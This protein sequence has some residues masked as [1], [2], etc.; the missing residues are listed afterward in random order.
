MY[1][2]PSKRDHPTIW[3]SKKIIKHWGEIGNLLMY[4]DFHAHASKKGVFMF[5][6][7]YPDPS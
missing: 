2:E 6:N 7:S 1:S 4:I 3:A 5:G